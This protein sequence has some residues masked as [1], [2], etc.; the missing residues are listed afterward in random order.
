MTPDWPPR[1]PHPRAGTR[2]FV[3]AQPPQHLVECQFVEIERPHS[4][5]QLVQHHSQRVHVGARVHVRSGRAGLLGTHVGRRPQNRSRLREQG[6]GGQR[7][8]NG[9]G[10]AEVDDTRHRLAVHF[11][12]QNV[13]WLQI[14]MDDGFLVRMLYALAD[15]NE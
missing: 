13:G 12:H 14:A 8:R 11:A 5:Q 15:L 3:F 2:R 1:V 4:D 9:L 6:F 7:L 10:Y